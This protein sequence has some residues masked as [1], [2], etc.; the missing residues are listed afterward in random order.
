MA[1]LDPDS[2]RTLLSEISYPGFSRD[3]VSFGLVKEIKIEGLDI[4]IKLE[5]QANNPDIPQTIF[6]ACHKKLDSLNPDGQVIIDIDIKDPPEGTR[7]DQTIQKDSKT[8]LPGVKKVIAI[9]SG[10]GGVGKSTVTANLAISL[11]KTGARV[12]ICDCDLY[13]PSMTMMFGQ[14]NAELLANPEDEIIPIQAHGIQLMSMGFL[15]EKDSP[16]VVRGPLATRY[17]QQFLRQVAWDNLDYLLLDL[18]PGTGDIQLTIV[19]T[20]ALDGAVIVTTPQDIAIIDAQKAS[21]MFK[22]VNVNILGLIEN[23]SYF[24]CEHGTR[25]HPFGKGGGQ[26]EATRLNIAFLGEIP[27]D[28]QTQERGNTGEPIALVEDHPVSQ[29]FSKIAQV[30]S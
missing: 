16:V 22:K 26:K 20:V 19:Q 1:I 28:I 6:Q 12:G 17:T 23:M 2:V 8:S 9:A 29:A 15:L 3:I 10:K 24:K 14:N 5:I 18:P 11:A 21:A 4:S 25:Y 27:L 7:Q 13:G 30:L